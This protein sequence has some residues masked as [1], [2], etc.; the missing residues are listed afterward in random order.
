MRNVFFNG[1]TNETVQQKYIYDNMKVHVIIYVFIYDN[2]NI[3]GSICR[4]IIHF[5]TSQNFQKLLKTPPTSYTWLFTY[6]IFHSPSADFAQLDGSFLYVF[7][8]KYFP[9][10][11]NSLQFLLYN[12]SIHLLFSISYIF[13]DDYFKNKYSVK[14]CSQ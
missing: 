11:L 6:Y 8:Y 9:I 7:C 2:M 12:I 4:Q 13:N 14:A 3:C 10:H 1:S 5:K